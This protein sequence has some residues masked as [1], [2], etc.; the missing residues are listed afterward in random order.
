MNKVAVYQRSSGSGVLVGLEDGRQH[1]ERAP[2]Y[3][4]IKFLQK[5]FADWAE[6]G[7]GASEE[8]PF[9]MGLV[10]KEQPDKLNS[11]I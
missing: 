7:V 5:K 8:V 11:Q 4:I 6:G 2:G 3:D 10:K 1:S 9:A